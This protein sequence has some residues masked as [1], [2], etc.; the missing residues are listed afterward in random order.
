MLLRRVLSGRGSDR[1][2]EQEQGRF[3]CDHR[4]IPT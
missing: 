3:Q 2:I 1:L 4:L